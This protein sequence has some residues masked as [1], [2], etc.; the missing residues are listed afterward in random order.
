M[1]TIKATSEA[2]ESNS[3]TILKKSCEQISI[4]LNIAEFV[5]SCFN[6]ANLSDD[7]KKL[8]K[9]L[10]DRLFHEN[11]ELICTLTANNRSLTEELVQLKADLLVAQETISEKQAQLDSA[12][13]TVRKT[14][15]TL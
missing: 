4:C 3:Q 11:S 2:F 9:S 12:K 8:L 6:M 7:N 1:V 13:R 15:H 5:S 10:Y 14:R